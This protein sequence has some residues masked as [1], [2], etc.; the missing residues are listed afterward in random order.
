M[1]T[2]AF[3]CTQLKKQR[4]H[5][6]GDKHVYDDD[7]A[8]A[9]RDLKKAVAVGKTVQHAAQDRCDNARTQQSAVK[10]Q[11]FR[12]HDGPGRD[13]QCQRVGNPSWMLRPR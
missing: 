3:F 8:G 4:Q 5:E 12:A 7:A 10:K 6:H 2:R 9:G 11:I 1:A 13:G